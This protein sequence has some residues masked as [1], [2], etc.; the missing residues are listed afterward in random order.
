MYVCICNMLRAHPWWIYENSS[1]KEKGKRKL[2]DPPHIIPPLVCIVYMGM[3]ERSI[4]LLIYTHV[5][6]ILNTCRLKTTTTNI[7]LGVNLRNGGLYR[8]C[9][10]LYSLSGFFFLLREYIWPVYYISVC[11]TLNAYLSA[12]DVMFD[13]WL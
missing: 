4:I 2:N 6:Y 1:A 12:C 11:K 10:I 9:R 3:S 5:L 13:G 8:I 7:F